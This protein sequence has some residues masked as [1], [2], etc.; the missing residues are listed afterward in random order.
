MHHSSSLLSLSK[1]SRHAQNLEQLVGT[2]VSWD[3]KV[4]FTKSI[5]RSLPTRK[6]FLATSSSSLSFSRHESSGEFSHDISLHFFFHFY[7][8]SRCFLFREKS[9]D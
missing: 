9:K 4:K 6:T 1:S 2:R 7:S 3:K 5:V 8:S